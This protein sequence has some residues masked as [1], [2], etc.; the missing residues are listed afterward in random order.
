MVLKVTAGMLW[1]WFRQ[2]KEYG[3]DVYFLV[4]LTAIA[5]VPLI[6]FR[7]TAWINEPYVT[8]G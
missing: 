2:L 7:E 4:A 3:Q 5:S 1:P 6:V 8:I